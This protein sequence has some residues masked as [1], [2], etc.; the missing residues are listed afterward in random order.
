MKVDSPSPQL[1]RRYIAITISDLQLQGLNFGDFAKFPDS[2]TPE[3]G[4]FD[5][6]DAQSD[7]VSEAIC[8]VLD[9][10]VIVIN[11]SVFF[12]NA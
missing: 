1:Q 6:I 9:E 4:Q 8:F 7:A 2:R 12:P 11:S 5:L 10:V 3:L